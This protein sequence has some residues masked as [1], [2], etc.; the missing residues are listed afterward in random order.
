VKLLRAS[1]GVRENDEGAFSNA[2]TSHDGIKL[3]W[4]KLHGGDVVIAKNQ[5]ALCV[6]CE[7]L[8]LTWTT[9]LKGGGL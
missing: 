2:C 4:L 8:A 6:E 7:S 1:V 9:T 5:R 3:V